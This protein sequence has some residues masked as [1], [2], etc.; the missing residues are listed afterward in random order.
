MDDDELLLRFQMSTSAAVTAV[1]NVVLPPFEKIDVSFIDRRGLSGRGM[2]KKKYR[3]FNHEH[4]KKCIKEDYLGPDALFGK[5]FP[6]M[7]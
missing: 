1:A 3:Q 6:L 2:K 7:F 4:A 5:E